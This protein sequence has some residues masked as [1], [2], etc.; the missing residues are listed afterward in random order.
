M[1]SVFPVGQNLQ[2]AYTAKRDHACR[3]GNRGGFAG[4]DPGNGVRKAVDRVPRGCRLAR[5]HAAR[6]SRPKAGKRRPEAD[7]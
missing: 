7:L 6:N 2:L 3:D 1:L 4:P 5:R